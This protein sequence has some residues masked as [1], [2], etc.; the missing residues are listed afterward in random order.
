MNNTLTNKMLK[1]KTRPTG[2]VTSSHF[3]LVE[4]S[5]PDLEEGQILVKV[6]YLSFDPT[7]RGWLNDVKSYV[8]PV[9][10]GEVM[11]AGSVGQ[12]IDSRDS[13]FKSGDIVQGSFGWQE[14]ATVNS[15]SGIMPIQ[16][17]P[18]G[19]PP[20][21]ALSIYGITGL[22][23]F[24]GMVDIGKP[25]EGD[26]VLVSGAA[27]ATGSVAGQIARIK[28]AKNVIGIAGGSD[29]CNWVVNEAGFDSCIDYKN[30]DVAARIAELAPK[31]IDIYF[32]NVGGNI[33]EIALAA[34][35]QNARIVMCGGI[36]SGYTMESLPPGPSTLTNLII[37]RGRME[38]FIVLDF[39]DRFLEAII[40]LGTWVSEGKIVYQEDIAEGLEN[41]PETLARLFEGKNLGKQLLKIADVV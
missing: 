26:T 11:R 5:I 37:Q 24:F 39:A 22:T 8:P 12:V 15:S 35:A 9:Q 28:G 6:L 25:V 20:T 1:L 14:Y 19:I 23:A 33:L 36:S 34:I 3:E 13:K 18:E 32:D 4:E 16:K 29:K 30:E 7:Q 17:V 38:G 40:A 41:C 27:G 21:S 31:G 2:A 10:I